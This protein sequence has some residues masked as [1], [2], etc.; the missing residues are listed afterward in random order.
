MV[1]NVVCPVGARAGE[2]KV[3][4]EWECISPRPLMTHPRA[5]KGLPATPA[6]HSRAARPRGGC[7]E[8]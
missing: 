3:A 5:R 7:S 4:V 6:A 8:E 1:S 2:W